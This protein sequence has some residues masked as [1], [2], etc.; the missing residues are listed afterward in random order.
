VNITMSP[1]SSVFS[2]ISLAGILSS[3]SDL[4][5][6]RHP[7]LG[8]GLLNAIEPPILTSKLARRRRMSAPAK[9]SSRI[10]ST[11]SGTSF[12]DSRF[13]LALGLRRL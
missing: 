8:Q 3:K 10:C 12:C 5:G 11:A 2:N 1:L 4:Y 9:K 7:P 13:T 6:N